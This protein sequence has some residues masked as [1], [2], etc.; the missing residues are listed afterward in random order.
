MSKLLINE[1]P[2]MVLPSLA[3]ALKNV[4]CAIVLQQIHY[5]IADPRA[6][7][8]EGVK[9]H[10]ATFEKWLEQFPWVSRRSLERIIA[11]LEGLSLIISKEFN[12]LKGDR[13]KWYTINYMALNALELQQ[14]IHPAKLAEPSRQIGGTIPPNWRALK[15][16]ETNKETTKENN[17]QATPPIEEN[18][19]QSENIVVCLNK[20]LLEQVMKFGVNNKTAKAWI[21]SYGE[22]EVKNKLRMLS[23]ELSKGVATSSTGGWLK[24]ALEDNWKP[25]DIK[26]SPPSYYSVE[27]TKK[28]IDDQLN[29]VKASQDVGKSHMNK[30]KKLVGK[31]R[32]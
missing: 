29:Y 7:E 12:R 3:V 9:W 27:E 1:N 20:E 17:K 21:Q 10:Y 26:K 18:M 30:I 5:W 32:G 4:D 24:R 6:P 8:R 2:L 11:K 22:D 25:C 23:I 31:P 16:K 19:N 15:G 13:T 14:I 28:R